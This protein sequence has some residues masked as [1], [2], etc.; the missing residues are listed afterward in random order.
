MGS[1]LPG[2]RRNHSGRCSCGN[3]VL[4]TGR[5]ELP[6]CHSPWGARSGK[7]GSPRRTHPAKAAPR[8]TG[9]LPCIAP[10]LQRRICNLQ[11]C[12]LECPGTQVYR[13]C[14]NA[15]PYTCS[16]LR[17][18][19]QCMQEDCQPGCICPPGQVM[20]GMLCVPVEEC[21][22]VIGQ[23][24]AV[25]WAANLSEEER[26]RE[27][28]PGSTFQHECNTCVCQRGV[29]ICTQEICDV[30]C[31][32]SEWSPWSSCPVT[33]GSGNQI[34]QRHPTQP[35][36]FNGAECQGPSVRWAPCT[37]PDCACPEGEHRQPAVPSTAC[38]RSCRQIYVELPRNCSWGPVQGACMCLPGHY[39]NSSGHC[40]VA[41]LCECEEGGQVYLAGAEWRRGCEICRCVN[42]RA[43]CETSCRPLV[44]LKDEVKVREL[45]SCCPICQ[46]DSDVGRHP[47]CRHFTERRN[48]TK[49]LCFLAGVEVGFCRGQCA[50]H[51]NVIPEEPYLQTVCDCCSYRLDPVSPVRILNLQCPRGETEPVVLPVI[52]GC[53]CSSCQGGDLSKR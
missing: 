36:M 46:K 45:G 20:Q 5:G 12:T 47:H 6:W 7:L 35:R 53:E 43:L 9:I 48:I 15:C 2:R 39:R 24:P 29:F 44:C 28:G 40:V 51:T 13:N 27:H 41:A 19:A 22:C 37:L 17:P 34:S 21:R 10:L 30:P 32:W 11:N 49:G 16:D 8:D 25:P 52:R 23:A 4:P 33:C 31:V 3:P 14:A 26:T 38:E 50:S 1:S 18:E 42:G